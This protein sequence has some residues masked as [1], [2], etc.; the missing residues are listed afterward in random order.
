MR[1]GEAHPAAKLTAADVADIRV[2]HALGESLAALG[3]AFRVDRST[4]RA[5]V[6]GWTWKRRRP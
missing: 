4:I 3:R 2:R 1:S 5:V 6:L